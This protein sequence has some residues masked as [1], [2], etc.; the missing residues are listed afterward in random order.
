MHVT[1]R[2]NLSD[3]AGPEKSGV[4]E[5][6]GSLF[7]GAQQTGSIYPGPEGPVNSSLG[8]L[9]RE[10]AVLREFGEMQK[11]TSVTIGGFASYISL[12][13]IYV[14]KIRNKIAQ[15]NMYNAVVTPIV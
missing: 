10:Q 11:D 4:S 3:S 2:P 8:V 7:R 5:E 9:C 12:L 14:L 1:I 13:L 6:S 15:T